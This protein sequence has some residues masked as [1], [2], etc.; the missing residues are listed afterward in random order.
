MSGRM[1]PRRRAKRDAVEKDI[2][3]ALK[4]AGASVEQLDRP[5]D[6]VV[7]YR[8]MNKLMECKSPGGKLNEEQSL[9]F[10]KWKGQ[11]AVV[12]T[13]LEA[14]EVIGAMRGSKPTF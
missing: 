10:D 1:T 3:I 9:F 13:P 6:L 11:V 2:I 14:L 5:V 12:H 4:A 7:G 8:N